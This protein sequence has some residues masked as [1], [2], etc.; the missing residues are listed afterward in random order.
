MPVVDAKGYVS[1][2]Y[3]LELIN[4]TYDDLQYDVSI[5]NNEDASLIIPN[6]DS[7]LKGGEMTKKVLMVRIPQSTIKSNWTDLE[8]RVRAEGDIEKTFTTTFLSPMKT[9]RST[10]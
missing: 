8:I 2:S 3:M 1:N 4:K 5:L 7:T 9:E 6:M 10:P